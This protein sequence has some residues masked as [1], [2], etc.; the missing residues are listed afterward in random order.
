[1][2]D[3]IDK[4]YKDYR[5]L[6]KDHRKLRE[7]FLLGLAAALEKEGKGKKAKIIQQLIAHENQRLMFRKLASIYKK[8]ADLSIKCVTITDED[9]SKIITDKYEMER[10][11]IDENRKKYHQTEKSCPFM[12]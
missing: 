1:M 6:K 5:N 9:G 3:M 2:T 4:L 8:T 12:K 7:D 10:A 11:I